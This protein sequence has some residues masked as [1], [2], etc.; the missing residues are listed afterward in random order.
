MPV[1]CPPQR[2]EL[3][4]STDVC[5]RP[6]SGLASDAYGIG[7]I[8][9]PCN[10]QWSID[11]VC[12]AYRC[13]GSAGF[14]EECDQGWSLPDSRDQERSQKQR[15]GFPFHPIRNRAPVVGSV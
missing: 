9:F 6:V 10:A 11:Q 7:L 5:H 8:T 3:K 2:L 4:T 1:R 12:L 14:V 15:T 13:G